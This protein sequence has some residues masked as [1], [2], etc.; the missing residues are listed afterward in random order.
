M[1]YANAMASPHGLSIARRPTCL[2]KVH[3]G[4]IAKLSLALTT[5]LT[6]STPIRDPGLPGIR[7]FAMHPPG[8]KGDPE[9]NVRGQ[10]V[11]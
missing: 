3:S 2:L 7:V 5:H 6:Y 8:S 10:P 11:F 9:P 4:D 1:P